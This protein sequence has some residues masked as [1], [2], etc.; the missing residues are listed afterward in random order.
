[1]KLDIPY[2]EST[3][4]VP[5]DKMKMWTAALQLRAKYPFKIS[6]E[7]RHTLVSG[8]AKLAEGLK[9][10]KLT[11]I[12]YRSKSQVSCRIPYMLLDNTR[13]A[14]SSSVSDE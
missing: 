5:E 13:F 11:D 7:S 1:M 3:L 6:K 14:F 12:E 8:V 10:K 9:I 2:G 4:S